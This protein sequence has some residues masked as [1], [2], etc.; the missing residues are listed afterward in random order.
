MFPIFGSPQLA[1]PLAPSSRCLFHLD[2]SDPEWDA[3]GRILARTGHRGVFSR[4]ASLASVS[5]SV[6]TT[7]TAVNSQ[8]ALEARDLE[9]QGTR[10]AVCARMG[11]DDR[12]VFDNPPPPQAMSFFFEFGETGALAID[13]ATLFAISND[14]V[15]GGRFWV[16]T[17]GDYYRANYH[18][19]TSSVSSI[20]TAGQPTSGQRVRLFGYQLPGGQ[21]RISQRIGSAAATDGDESGPITLLPW[22][23]GAKV[24]IN[25]RGDTEN[26]GQA[27]YRRAKLVSGNVSVDLLERL[28]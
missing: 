21:L 24:R 6:G 27:A 20:L 26:P 10:H 18:N 11:P 14:A 4:G 22:G 3:D 13:D 12:L 9:G 2:F 15:T 17:D 23:A 5:D 1:A 19:G 28:R 25:A 7:Y 8:L 16:D